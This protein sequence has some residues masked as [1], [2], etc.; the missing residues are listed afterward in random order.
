MADLAELS[1]EGGYTSQEEGDGGC[2]K[3]I[4][5]G[6]SHAGRIADCLDN[7][8]HNVVDLSIPGWRNNEKNVEKLSLEPE[9]EVCIVYQLFDNSV[10]FAVKLDGTSVLPS[11]QEGKYHVEGDLS[12]ADR[13]VLK[14]LFSLASPLFSNHRQLV[15]YENE[16]PEVYF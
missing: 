10:S 4:I 5:L 9:V 11:K 6:G 12:M 16:R 7:M 14:S 8:G 3:F 2:K 1:C 13:S 15:R